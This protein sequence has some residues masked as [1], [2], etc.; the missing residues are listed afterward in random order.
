MRIAVISR[1]FAR[2]AGGAESYAVAVAQ[3]LALRH[4]VHVYA[5]ECPVPVAGVT[6]HRV[7]RLSRRPRWLNQLLFAAATWW[8]T[9]RGFDVVHSHENTWHG[10]IQ[11][12]HVRPLRYNQLQAGAGATPMARAL[13]FLKACT[14]PRLLTYA[15]LEAARFAPRSGRSVVATSETLLQECRFAYPGAERQFEVIVPGTTLPHAPSTPATAASA[16]STTS[17]MNMPAMS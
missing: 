13:Q 2:A 4:D 7:W 16:R 17:S 12:I 6:F 3:A 1:N 14:S 9:R 11:T 15:A 10:Q 5:Q 8:A